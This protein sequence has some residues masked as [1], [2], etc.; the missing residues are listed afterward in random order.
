MV[1]RNND[2]VGPSDGGGDGVPIVC[3]SAMT[4]DEII[5]MIRT[6]YFSN[7]TTSPVTV[8]KVN[9]SLVLNYGGD[10]A[11]GGTLVDP[12]S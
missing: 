4:E 11:T 7:V 10:N 9:N 2:F 8:D 1:I 5:G 12:G 6:N 3:A